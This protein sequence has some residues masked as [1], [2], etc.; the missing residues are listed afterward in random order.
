MTI[1]SLIRYSTIALLFSVGA[2]QQ[3]DSEKQ[4]E[5][6][7]TQ[8]KPSSEWQALLV[9]DSTGAT[10]TTEP[11]DAA[12]LAMVASELEGSKSPEKLQYQALIANTLAS[13]VPVLALDDLSDDK[14]RLAQ[15]LLLKD[16][17][18]QKV[19]FVINLSTNKKEPLRNEVMSVKPALPGDRVGT[20]SVCAIGQCYRIDIYNFF[21]NVT[22]TG[23][24][25]VDNQQ[26]VVINSLPESQPDLSARLEALAV[27]IAKHEPAVRYEVDRY[28]KFKGAD[29]TQEEILPLM[30][31]TKSA[32]KNSLC[33][34]SKHL[35]VAP[36]YVLGDQ[37]LWVIVDLTD[38]KVVGLRWTIVGDTDPPVIMTQRIIENEYV[39]KNYCEQITALERSGWNLNYHLTASDGLR[40]ADVTYQDKPVF[41][42]AKVV[43][44][45]VSYS[46]QDGFGY[47]DATGCPMFSSAVVVGY[48]GP[49]IEPIVEN[50]IE[51]GFAVA[52]DFRQLPWPAACNYR[53][54]ERYEFYNDGRYRVALSNHGR[55]CG[56]NG[57][58][59]P[60]LRIEVGRSTEQQSYALQ[61]WQ[62]NDWQ[63][64]EQE[65]W[66]RQPQEK[67][68]NQGQYSHRLLDE[69][70]NG[71]L[72]SPS[73]GQF[74]DGGRG[75]DAFIYVTVSHPEK[76]EG[77]SDLV[78]LGS[79]CNTNHEQGPEQFMEPAEPLADQGLVLW[80]VPQIKN[81]G[82][83]GSEYCWANSIVV[84][85][86][87]EIQTWPCT[88][89]PMFVPTA[90]SSE[91]G[92]EQ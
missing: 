91:S 42:S 78:T 72:L 48:D 52:Q 12:K 17:G 34:R 4:Q 80:Y 28:L 71:Y 75:D 47:S 37:A 40:I 76:D 19:L 68:L 83:E 41:N 16:D 14:A 46:R 61:Q 23:I 20:A 36:T 3:S 60:V 45:H 15:D 89:G 7:A 51:V 57:T 13:E 39:F 30:V 2:C 74:G 65:A 11:Y 31:S 85:G 21:F 58:Y 6:S 81:D 73:I 87:H 8:L 69:A 24:V 38:M 63:T 25:D 10:K 5:V 55:G 26:V 50:D 9:D 32:L 82:N 62:N 1:I 54:E 56:T 70:G 79:C 18:L 66:V 77:N 27:S 22:V 49:K 64:V 84:D 86:V 53:Y 44:W 92:V 67:D 29:S 33:E 88:G 90:V 35:C 59:R 43:D